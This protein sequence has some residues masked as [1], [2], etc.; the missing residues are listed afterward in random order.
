MASAD[1]S[2]TG[3]QSVV[4]KKRRS[5][6]SWS[7]DRPCPISSIRFWVAGKRAIPNYDCCPWDFYESFVRFTSGLCLVQRNDGTDVRVITA[8]TI[9][10]DNNESD[11]KGS[12]ILEIQ[13]PNF[14]DIY[15]V[16]HFEDQVFLIS[17]Y[18]DFSLDDLL[19]CSIYPTELEIGCIISQVR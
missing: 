12:S 15:E 18:V 10:R 6:I 19:Q 14:I 16:Y 2:S 8:Y 5:S 17:E 3:T 1:T 7:V 9:T 4:P 13:H 11:S